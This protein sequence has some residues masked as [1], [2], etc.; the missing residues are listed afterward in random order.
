M[1]TLNSNLNKLLLLSMLLL[2][3]TGFSAEGEAANTVVE[4][5][6]Y[7][8]MGLTSTQLFIVMLVFTVI[9]FI[10]AI[11]ASVT[12]SNSAGYLERKN[13]ENKGSAGKAA[14]LLALLA[15]IP[16]LS[17]G[18]SEVTEPS[19]E[20]PFDDNSFY[21]VLLFDI[22]LVAYTMYMLGVSNGLIGVLHPRKKKRSAFKLW[23]E[24]LVDATPIEQ[25]G[26][27]TLDHEYD[28]IRELDNNL[29][30]WW[31]YGFY[32]TIVW[33]VGYLTY[34]HLLGGPL[35]EQ[36]YLTEM[37]EGELEVAQYIA[38]H[39][40]QINANNVE[41]LTDEATLNKGRGLFKKHCVTCHMDGGAGGA[42]PNLTDKYWIYD[43]D[44]KGVFTTISEGANNGMKAWKTQLNGIEIQA[45][46]SYVLQLD[47]ILPPLGQEPKGENVFERQ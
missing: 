6:I 1:K 20:I 41:L 25:E 36:E 33:A 12:A 46:A 45:V 47:P 26:S 31:K 19:F 30:P 16:Q 39:P 38:D 43:G 3:F 42:G 32:I 29:P 4:Q 8:K 18:A 34:Y 44:I 37:V 22:C 28:G 11:L 40:E 9:L 21:A 14:G 17:F 35:Q 7:Q 15:F 27:I 2:T 24:K 13:K 10:F 5:T 23:K